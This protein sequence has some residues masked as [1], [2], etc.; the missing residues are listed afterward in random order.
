MT[1]E[2][3]DSAVS[4][5][6]SRNTYVP[7]A[8]NVAVVLRAFAFTKLTEPGPLNL[9]QFVV[10]VPFVGKPSFVTVPERLA[11]AGSEIV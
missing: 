10:R 9:D 3:E 7:E 5:A 1:S 8:E 11:P 6:V 2:L 4:P